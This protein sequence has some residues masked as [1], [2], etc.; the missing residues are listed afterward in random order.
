[1]L[2]LILLALV[3]LGSSEKVEICYGGNYEVPIYYTPPLFK[4][5]IYF[6]PR[7]EERT[8][9]VSAEGKSQQKRILAYTG[10]VV[11]QDLTEQDNGAM[12]FFGRASVELEIL[13]C[14]DPQISR[15]GDL[16]SWMVP[17]GAEYLEFSH[18]SSDYARKPQVIWNRTDAS[19]GRGRVKRNYFEI[20]NVKQKDS[21]YYKLRALRGDLIRWKRLIVEESYHHSTHMEGDKLRIRVK[22]SKVD[23]VL[24]TRQGSDHEES[25]EDMGHRMEIYDSYLSFWGLMYEDSGTYKF[26]DEEGFLALRM[27]LEVQYSSLIAYIFSLPIPYIIGIV[28]AV[29]CAVCCCCCCVKKC[30]CKKSSRK[31]S[32]P[33]TEAAA[34]RVFYHDS[35]QPTQPTQPVIPLLSR[36][37]RAITTDPPMYNSAVDNMNLSPSNNIMPS[38]QITA[39]GGLG[40]T[41]TPMIPTNSDSDPK[42]EFK[43]TIF[44]SAPPLSSGTSIQDVYTS[45]KLNFL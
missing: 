44:P 9:A 4:K 3:D 31:R 40:P 8:L 10:R 13:D 15:Y 22:F 6:K 12:L 24:F 17:S 2:L 38:S 11:L 34:P 45:D 19:L 42:F 28:A 32:S 33:E 18:M 30:C 16:F 21:G 25:F 29:L 23:H 26:I 41:S 39:S 43:G 35:N 5:P 1:M 37:P 20:N 14:Q 36:E 27:E 7:G